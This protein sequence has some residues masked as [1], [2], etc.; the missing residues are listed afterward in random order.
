MYDHLLPRK[1]YF[2]KKTHTSCPRDVKCR[3]CGHAQESVP[4]ILAGCSALAQNKYLFKHHDMALKVLFYEILHD[5]DLL[6]EVPVM[7]KPVY[8]SEQVEAWW[9]VPVYADHQ[10]VRGKGRCERL[11]LGQ[12]W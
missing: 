9:D 5:Q 7:P 2:S 12:F 10:E 11:R 3:L 8:R 1:L 6:E 4:H